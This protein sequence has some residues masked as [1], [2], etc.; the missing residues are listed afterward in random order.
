MSKLCHINKLPISAVKVFKETKPQ[1]EK[2]SS[3]EEYEKA[4]S[5]WRLNIM[6]YELEYSKKSTQ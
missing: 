5:S 1:R 3:N 6:L 4:Y 2:F